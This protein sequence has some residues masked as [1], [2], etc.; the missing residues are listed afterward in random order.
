MTDLLL[1]IGPEQ[2]DED[3]LEETV[4][5]RPKRVT[6][7]IE[8]GDREWAWDDSPAGLALRDRLAKL[9]HSIERRTNA[10]V[11]GLAGKREQLFGWR[12]DGVIGG[13]VPAAA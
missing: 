2:R 13:A 7:L 3:L 9:L 12:F 5:A 6:V 1:I 11:V 4:S 8:D 10:K